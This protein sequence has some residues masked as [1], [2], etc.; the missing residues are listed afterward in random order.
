M[1]IRP[2]GERAR[3]AASATEGNA[4]A[5]P[6]AVGS[7]LRLQAFAMLWVAWLVANTC[8]WVCDVA[9]AW[10]MAERSPQPMLVALVQTAAALPVF[11]LALPSGATADIVDRRRWFLA[12]QFWLAGTAGLLALASWMGALSPPVLLALVFVNGMGMALRWPVYA[13]IVPELVGRHQLPQALALPGLG[14]NVARVLGPLVAGLLLALQGPTF[15][16]AFSALLSLASMALIWRWRYVPQAKAL[17][18]ERFLR[19]MR[20][21]VQ[22]VTQSPPVRVTLV[23]IFVLFVQSNAL[24]ALLPLVAK[25]L[26]DGGAGTY[27]TLFSCMGLGAIVVAFG[28][29]RLRQAVGTSTIV[30]GGTLVLAASTA[31]VALAPS[32]WIAAPAMLFAGASWLAAANTV[33]VGTQLALPDWVRARGMAVFLVAAMAG[34]AFGA[35]MFGAV[36]DRTGVRSSLVLLAML[37]PIVCWLLRRW[38]IDERIGEDLAPQPHTER[39]PGADEIEPGAGPVVVTIE[40]SIDAQDEMAF[41]RVMEDC[42]RARLRGGALSWN[43]LRDTADPRRHVETFVDATWVDH[44]RRFDRLTAGD[45]RLKDRRLALHR[46]AQPPKVTRYIDRRPLGSHVSDIAS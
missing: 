43:L 17:P 36:A 24:L 37:A 13:A 26:G 16:F 44:L 2:A 23:R 4:E 8:M 6:A 32:L 41:G 42:R 35:A 14:V 31:A 19:A 15:V 25:G 11:A 28:L 3:G 5:P 30:N 10:L 21:G 12:T 39:P 46:G 22:Y 27:T 38:R 34:A 7:P 40:Y 1:A 18:R 20:V 29:P 33:N 9:A 45:A